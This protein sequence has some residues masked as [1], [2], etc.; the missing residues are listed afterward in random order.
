MNLE[1]FNSVIEK[2]L[3]VFYF[4]HRYF[5][6]R[7]DYHYQCNS[8]PDDQVAAAYQSV[9]AVQGDYCAV[10]L[11]LV[12][13]IFQFNTISWLL[14]NSLSVGIM[15]AVVIFQ[16]ELRRALEELGRKNLFR[17]FIFSSEEYEG[18]DASLNEKTI[19][20]IVKAS[21]EMSKVKTGALIVIEQ[22]VALG[23][24][25]VPALP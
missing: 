11:A 4:N 9:D 19:T 22:K 13:V 24:Y 10:A 21:F 12:A 20:E 5:G 25:S 6:Y 23:E 1:Q 18:R 14:S 16:P 8:V 2:Y 17:N 3:P 15:A 7:G